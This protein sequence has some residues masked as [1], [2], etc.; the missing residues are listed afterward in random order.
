[1]FH[2]ITLFPKKIHEFKNNVNWENNE[3]NV[4]TIEKLHLP[5]NLF[6]RNLVLIY[7]KLALPTRVLNSL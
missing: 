7:S 1:M 2:A 4:N 3:N 5:F 6:L